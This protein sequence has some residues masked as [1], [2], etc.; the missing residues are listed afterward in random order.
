MARKKQSPALSVL[1]TQREIDALCETCREEKRCAFDTE[2]VM[3]DRYESEVCLIQVATEH[4]VALIDPFQDLNLAPIWR[5]VSEPKIETI[6]HAG[7]EDLALAV[8][9]TGDVP[10][11]IFDVQITAGLVGLD[12]PISLQR[13]VL[14]TLHLRLHKSKTLTDWRRRPLS[15]DQLRYAAED[16]IHL[17]A[18]RKYI[19]KKLTELQRV[20]WAGEE[21]RR[22]EDISFYRRVEEDKISRVKGAGSLNGRQLAAV[23]ELM[24]W[25][26][27]F[28]Q[29]L[30]RPARV[31]LKDHLLVEIAKHGMTEFAEVRSLRG[32]NLSD[33]D[34][35]SLCRAVK[36][37]GTLKEAEWPKPKPR[38]NETP[39]EGALA[40]LATAVVRGYCLENKV[41]FGLAT[42][43]K[44]IKDLIR[45]HEGTGDRNG[46]E[47]LQG[48]RG[49]TIGKLVD[50]VL[51]G[52]RN[53]V[54]GRV[55]NT[56]VVLT[57]PRKKGG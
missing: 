16:V 19:G 31:V 30:N 14:A 51:A 28:A 3:E 7:Q 55:D 5:L 12:Y 6:V 40:A 8:Q 22:F 26:E 24:Q 23:R 32:I 45:C 33:R 46:A 49:K 11:N 13:L 44:A 43:Q 21:L 54:V 34:V 41:A 25:R 39:G 1:K 17:H 37:A 4:T 18:V 35:H 10:K 38:V 15:D 52:N 2:F 48:W 56:P 9:H 27:R 20:E 57:S 36:K 47:I 42:T 53:V 50:D 29:R